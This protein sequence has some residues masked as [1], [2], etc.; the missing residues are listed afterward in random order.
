VKEFPNE[1]GMSK[2]FVDC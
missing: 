2:A 1:G